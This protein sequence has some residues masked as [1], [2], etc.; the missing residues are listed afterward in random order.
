[1][2]I[3]LAL[4][5]ASLALALAPIAPVAPVARAAGVL[6]PSDG[7]PPLELAREQVEARICD[8]LATTR[9]VEI[10]RNP[11]D[12]PLEAVYELT[13]PRGANVTDFVLWIEGKPVRGDVIDREEA[14]RQYEAI[15][16]RA[17]DPGLLEQS[18][19]ATFRIRVF[20]VPARG[21]QRVELEYFERLVAEGGVFRYVYLARPRG[22][23]GAAP[24]AAPGSAPPPAPAPVLGFRLRLRSSVPVDGVMSPSH[25]VDVRVAGSGPRPAG[26]LAA[27]DEEVVVGCEASIENDLEVRYAIA[28]AESG[29][30]VRLHRPLPDEPGYFLAAIT[31]GDSLE[32]AGAADRAAARLPKDVTFVLDTSGSMGGVKIAQAK[33]AVRETIAALSE[34]DGVNL[35]AFSSA[36]VRWKPAPVAATKEAREEALVF[37]EKFAAEGSTALDEALAAALA[38]AGEPG[39][40][41]LVLLLTDGRPTTGETRPEAILERAAAAAA[42]H[43]RVFTFGVGDD[44]DARLLEEIAEATRA[45]AETIA[46]GEPIDW[47]VAA[48]RRKLDAPVLADLE[49]DVDGLDA[50][51][52]LPRRL[53]DLF[54]GTQLLVAGRFKRDAGEARVRVRGVGRG[55]VPV[56]IERPVAVPA[57]R[58][59]D[60]E[61]ARFFAGRKVAAL[62]APHA[63]KPATVPA[64]VRAEVVTLGKRFRI[65]TPYT[66]FFVPEPEAQA[67]GGDGAAG[68]PGSAPAG[69]APPGTDGI[70]RGTSLDPGANRNR[71][72]GSTADAS[73]VGGGAAPRY[74]E[75]W[76]QGSLTREG[77]SMAESA[78]TV[79][80]RWLVRHQEAD[81][82]WACQEPDRRC[83]GEGCTGL[84]LLAFLGG[85]HTH[86]HS[87]HPE[88]RKAVKGA[89]AHLL[90][91]QRD[92]GSIGREDGDP[93]TTRDHALATFA[94]CEAYAVSRDFVLRK[95]AQRAVDVCIARARDARALDALDPATLGFLAAALNAAGVAGLDV[96]PDALE[97][98]LA[99][100]ERPARDGASGGPPTHVA[101]A[102]LCRLFLGGKPTDPEVRDGVKRLQGDLPRRDDEKGGSRADL[103]HWC[104]ATDAVLR[105]TPRGSPEWKTW[106]DALRAAVLGPAD[107]AGDPRKGRQRVGGDEDGSFDPVADWW[108]SCGRVHATAFHALI[109]E[110]RDR[111]E[112]RPP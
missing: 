62:L 27:A 12:R 35:V 111:H 6:R 40:P 78:A 102:V 79:A 21:E 20:P 37:V 4:G 88:F 105:A 44:L 103:D 39:R 5:A 34:G 76:G 10:F 87:T 99:A 1:M 26:P 89:L 24:D 74:G 38:H 97:G 84:A 7:G 108:A 15:V 95:P 57:V 104:L 94:L 82:R 68:A 32:A 64:E 48:L 109:L 101:A 70:P 49:L 50:F 13:L 11:H 17:R 22:V 59:E 96:P 45:V 58:A 71:E 92:D 16:R 85:G 90:S 3:A 29:I 52:V 2:R 54:A 112:R 80:L 61:I 33:T 110:V 67:S 81:G 55:G 31:A 30:D 83:T 19:E 56:A 53:P 51:D 100:L 63:R 60:P 47:K 106:D 43:T 86:R 23:P 73:G 75:R 98:L 107:R 8:G 93:A 69:G 46:P 41:H 36:A 65:A 14:R 9:V 66:S 25:A 72:A 42:R 18:G 77:G 28:R 91:R